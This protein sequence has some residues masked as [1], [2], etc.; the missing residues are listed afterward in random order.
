MI[1]ITVKLAVAVAVAVAVAITT[2]IIIKSIYKHKIFNYYATTC[3]SFY[4]KRYVIFVV[5]LFITVGVIVI[6]IITF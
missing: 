1:I 4:L 5:A 3:V 2:T 6:I